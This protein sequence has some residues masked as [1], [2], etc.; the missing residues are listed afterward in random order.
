MR[1]RRALMENTSMEHS[2]RVDMRLTPQGECYTLE[3]N[4]N[5]WLHSS[6]EFAVAAK[7]SG[8]EHADLIQEIVDLALARCRGGRLSVP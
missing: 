5:P 6:A 4:P 1:S 8:R 2:A 7:R 3:V